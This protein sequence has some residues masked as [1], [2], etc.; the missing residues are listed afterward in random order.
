MLAPCTLPRARPI[1]CAAT[2]RIDRRDPR[3]EVTYPQEGRL[4]AAA[5]EAG[6][7]D[8]AEQQRLGRPRHAGHVRHRSGLD[9]RLL[10]DRRLAAHRRPGQLEH[11]GRL[12]LHRRRVRCLHAV[13]VGALPTGSPPSYPQA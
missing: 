3:A 7:G 8:Q 10:C 4:H 2:Q 9:R 12:R 13:E 6:R 5:G 1:P 11:R